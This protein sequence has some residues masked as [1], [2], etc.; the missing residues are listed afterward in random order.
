MY[1]LDVESTYSEATLRRA[2]GLAFVDERDFPKLS[3]NGE[4]GDWP[5]DSIVQTS[6]G[7]SFLALRSGFSLESRELAAIARP[8]DIVRLDRR[9]AR[10]V[11]SEH[12]RHNTLLVTEE[13]DNLCLFC[14]QPPRP[15]GSYFREAQRALANFRGEGTVGLSGGEPTM[16][17]Q[18]LLRLLSNKETWKGRHRGDA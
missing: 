17:W 3:G 2:M 7:Q 9:A 16:F 10:V 18:E 6:E 1:G 14:S 12:S 15:S 11:L 5:I 13:C 8:G 4:T